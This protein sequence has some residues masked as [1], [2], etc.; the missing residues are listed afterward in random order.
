MSQGKPPSPTEKEN[1]TF[2]LAKSTN[3]KLGLWTL[4]PAAGRAKYG[5]KSEIADQLLNRLFDACAKGEDSI[6]I[7]DIRFKLTPEK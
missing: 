5:L 2:A 6:N 7:R 1:V 3:A 4:D